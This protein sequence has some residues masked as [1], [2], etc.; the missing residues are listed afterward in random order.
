MTAPDDGHETADRLDDLRRRVAELE[1]Q[2][3]NATDALIGAEAATA[4]ARRDID[5][6]FHRLH[7]RES[8]LKALKE[9]LGYELETPVSE[10][11]PTLGRRS[12]PSTRQA[13]R[14]SVRSRPRR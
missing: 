12:G 6:I 9:A 2:H 7:V 11:I 1:E 14:R 10:I 5:D 8:E 13:R 4:Q 3:L